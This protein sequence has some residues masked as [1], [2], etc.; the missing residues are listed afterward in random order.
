M[1]NEDM[2]IRST[3][4]G[5]AAGAFK[6]NAKYMSGGNVSQNED[7]LAVPAGLYLIQTPFPSTYSMNPTDQVVDNQLY[8]RLIATIEV[9]PSTR[10][11]SKKKSHKSV[12]ST[13]RK[14]S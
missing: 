10:N 9:V 13:R 12:K 5:P 4:E 14:K 1:M 6:L 7:G 11:Q 2:V 8:E 3:P